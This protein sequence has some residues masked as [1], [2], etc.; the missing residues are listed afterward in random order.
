MN[1]VV[2]VSRVQHV[3]TAV[4]FGL[5][6]C[7][8]C[9]ELMFIDFPKLTSRQKEIQLPT[10]AKSALRERASNKKLFAFVHKLLFARPRYLIMRFEFYQ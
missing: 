2:N 3:Q 9:Q 5:Y 8:C 1:K 6:H 7:V 10:F 4:Q